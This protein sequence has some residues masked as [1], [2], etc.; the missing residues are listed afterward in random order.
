MVEGLASV[1]RVSRCRMRTDNRPLSLPAVA[2]LAGICWGFLVGIAF[3]ILVRVLG[4][5]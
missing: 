3:V 5:A 1:R 4:A 2:F